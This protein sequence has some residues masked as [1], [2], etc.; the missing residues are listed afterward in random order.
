MR[1][2]PFVLLGLAVSLSSGCIIIAPNHNGK[3]A[4]E[5]QESLELDASSVRKTIIIEHSGHDSTSEEGVPVRKTVHQ[6]IIVNGEELKPGDFD[7]LPPEIK[8]II[9]KHGVK[10]DD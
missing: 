9:R 1:T 2:L 10:V 6:T 7:S 4:T 5:R 8:E 3:R